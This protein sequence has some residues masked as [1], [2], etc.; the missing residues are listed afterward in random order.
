VVADDDMTCPLSSSGNP[1]VSPR[2][3]FCSRFPPPFRPPRPRHRTTTVL[4]VNDNAEQRWQRSSSLRRE[5]EKSGSS[6]HSL[7]GSAILLQS[8][9]LWDRSTRP[10]PRP[11]LPWPTDTQA[12]YG[13]AN[14]HSLA[15]TPGW[16]YRRSRVKHRPQDRKSSPR[17]Y[18]PASL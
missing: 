14:N 6:F 7:E 11:P 1:F 12:R 8:C 13:P 5:E 4:T 9:H 15:A 17:R 10:V 16:P 18:P 2:D 3:H